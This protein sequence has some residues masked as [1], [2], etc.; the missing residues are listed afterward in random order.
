M[1]S[2]FITAFLIAF[3]F[4]LTACGDPKPAQYPP[5]LYKD[6]E[7]PLTDEELARV[8]E[9]AEAAK[10]AEEIV[11]GEDHSIDDEMER[12]KELDESEEIYPGEDHSID[13]EMEE[14]KDDNDDDDDD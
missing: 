10:A 7:D 6:L 5:S 4:T 11:P 14:A 8:K 13:D 9:K 1:R 2:L 12:A 3:T